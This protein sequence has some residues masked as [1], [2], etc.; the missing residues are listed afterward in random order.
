MDA[1]AH[2]CPN[3]QFCP[4]APKR[5]QD[6][7]T[8]PPWFINWMEANMASQEDDDTPPTWFMDYMADHKHDC[9]DSLTKKVKENQKQIRILLI[10]SSVIIKG[11]DH[12]NRLLT[13]D[14]TH[15]TP[16]RLLLSEAEARAHINRLTTTNG[17]RA[18]TR[19]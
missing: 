2:Y 17:M 1:K 12:I 5:Q 8:P 14:M 11:M 19:S 3:C 15:P 6:D 10:E 18:P 4:K 9:L 13:T 16:D 7:N